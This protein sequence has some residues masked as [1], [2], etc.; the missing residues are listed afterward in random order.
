ME[1]PT[2]PNRNY[3]PLIIGLTIFIYAGI[4]LASYIPGI[5]ILQQYDLS[6][7]PALNA[8]LNSLNFLALSAALMAILK[9]NVVLHRRFIGL[10]LFFT[11]LFLVSYLAYHLGTESTK[12]GGEGPLR[13]VY[14][15]ILLTHIVLA[16]A[17]VPLALTSIA[18]GLNMEVERHRK[19]ARITMPIWLYVSATGVI[20][21]FMISP[22]YGS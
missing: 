4:A 22:Y 20:V 3:R 9:K 16:A 6:K 18:R 17:I 19:I 5:E 1:Q 2:I 12:Y 8:L 11:S 13:Y 15:F 10:A 21:Y 7:L 14:Y